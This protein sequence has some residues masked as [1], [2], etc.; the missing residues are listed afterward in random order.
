MLVRIRTPAGLDWGANQYSKYYE[1]LF[2][3]FDDVLGNAGG[4]LVAR[5]GEIL[6]PRSLLTLVRDGLPPS[7]NG[8]SFST[9][10]RGEELI[11]SWNLENVGVHS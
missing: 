10:L 3:R 8:G 5:C 1:F 2:S 11:A 7:Y 9:V 6:R 4:C